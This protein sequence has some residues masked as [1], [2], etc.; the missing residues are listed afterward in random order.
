MGGG[1]TDKACITMRR[2]AQLRARRERPDGGVSVNSNERPTDSWRGG[3]Q[4]GQ[5]HAIIA[6]TALRLE[7]RW[8]NDACIVTY[9]LL[10]LQ[11]QLVL[12]MLVSHL[13]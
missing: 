7:R 8:G 13:F 6:R 11:Q 5:E 2:T 12:V 1:R 10:L 4:N 9:R 3:R